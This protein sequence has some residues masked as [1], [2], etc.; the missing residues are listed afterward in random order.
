VQNYTWK[1]DAQQPVQTPTLS[2]YNY[3]QALIKGDYSTA[4]N[5]YAGSAQQQNGTEQQFAASFSRKPDDCTID[6]VNDASG[7]SSITVTYGPLKYPYDD[8]LT[9]VNGTWKINDE[10]ARSTPTLTLSEYC[11]DIKHKDYQSAYNLVDPAV[12]SQETES[13]FASNYSS[14]NISDCSVSNMN[15]TTGTGTITYT[16]ANGS[17]ALADYTMVNQSGTWK[18]E[19]EK[20]R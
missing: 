3:C 17:K 5:L 15:D 20:V 2:L 10:Q 13:V 19:S 9:N 6:T 1:I 7:K 4:Y 16:L 12:Q 8:T 14:A 18:V 11:Y